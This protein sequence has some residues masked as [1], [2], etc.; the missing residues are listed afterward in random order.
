MRTATHSMTRRAVAHD[1]TKTGIYHIT[2]HVADGLWQPLGDVAGDAMALDG[3]PDAPRVDMTPVGQMVEREL[4]HSIHEH[5]PMVIVDTYIIMPDHLHFILE[6]QDR[7]ISKNGKLLPLGQVIAGFKKG[8]NRRYWEM[9]GNAGGV[10]AAHTV[11]NSTAPGVPCASSA[12]HSVPG[13]SSAANSVPGA[14]SAAHSVPSASAA[15]SVSS[16]FPAGSKPP[17]N[18][19]TGRQPLFALGYC[20]VM[21]VDAA[22]LA[23]Q[24]AYIKGNP[25][26]RLQR[27]NNR[28]LLSVCRS[29]INTALTPSALR[30]FLKRECMAKHATPDALAAI[31]CRLLLADGFIACD[32]YGNRQLLNSHLLPVVCHHK[33]AQRFAEQKQHC[34]E[35]AARSAVLVSACISPREREIINECVNHGF[36][37]ITILDNGFPDRYHPSAEQQERCVADRLLLVSPW[38]YQYRGKNEQVTIPFCKTMNCVAQALCRMKD[39]WWK[40]CAPLN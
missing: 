38:G 7:I 34:L 17:S 28:S 31:E 23:T 39:D 21:P 6:V 30:G 9:T 4:L 36:P 24:R 26:S 16:G 10:T 37:V 20:D 35:A 5:Y 8:C 27:I 3:T 15:H 33:D 40:T 29:A 19:T 32:T 14:S 2:L 12:A 13:A 25:R 11:G 18:A 1:Y 22:Q